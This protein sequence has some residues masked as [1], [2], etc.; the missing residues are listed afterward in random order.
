MCVVFFEQPDA[1]DLGLISEVVGVHVPEIGVDRKC[2][3]E[4]PGTNL[5]LGERAPQLSV[6][7]IQIHHQSESRSG[8]LGMPQFVAKVGGLQEHVPFRSEPDGETLVRF[9]CLERFS[10]LVDPREV[11][12]RFDVGGILRD[13]L[14]V[15]RRR[16]VEIIGRGGNIGK[17][18]PV[19]DL[20][21]GDTDRFAGGIDGKGGFVQRRVAFREGEVHSVVRVRPER[22]LV[23]ESSVGVLSLHF[24]HR[25]RNEV[26]QRH[27]TPEVHLGGFGR[28]GP[29]GNR[30]LLPR[31]APQNA[32]GDCS[33]Q[34]EGRRTSAPAFSLHSTPFHYQKNIPFTRLNYKPALT[35]ERVFGIVHDSSAAELT[36]LWRK[37]S[38]SLSPGTGHMTVISSHS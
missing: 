5:C 22:F 3:V 13:D 6:P 27:F 21:G 10:H 37:R 14:F 38:T 35:P 15:L 33:G 8:T 19:F 16:A 24:I 1:G 17:E 23:F 18:F 7:R 31:S 11:V 4:V 34:K 29:G 28:S 25:A 32:H 26:R 36:T 12:P 2:I 9:E 20:P 30:R